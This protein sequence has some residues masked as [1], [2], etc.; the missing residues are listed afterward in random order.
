MGFISL[1]RSIKVSIPN[2]VV[3]GEEGKDSS[4]SVCSGFGGHRGH[5]LNLDL[6][7]LK[8]KPAWGLWVFLYSLFLGSHK[9]PTNL[10]FLSGYAEVAEGMLPRHAL[11]EPPRVVSAGLGEYPL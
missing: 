7:L 1:I 8:E 11:R 3:G 9:Q 6:W 5:N 10:R 2:K 4:C